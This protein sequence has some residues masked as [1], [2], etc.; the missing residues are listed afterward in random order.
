ASSSVACAGAPAELSPSSPC[1][2][3]IRA[4]ASTRPGR[5]S[6]PPTSAKFTSSQTSSPSRRSRPAPDPRERQD[7]IYTQCFHPA[8]HE[9]F[10]AQQT[11][12]N[13]SLT[14]L[15]QHHRLRIKSDPARIE[16]R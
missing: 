9:V 12:M 1:A 5:F 6:P 11:L 14:A 8:Q 3:G 7:E 2:D 4:S 10:S 15:V 16:P 13:E